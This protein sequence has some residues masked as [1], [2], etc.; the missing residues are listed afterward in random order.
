V[1][2]FDNDKAEV[3]CLAC[4]SFINISVTRFQ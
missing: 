2:A 4:C 1:H 3:L